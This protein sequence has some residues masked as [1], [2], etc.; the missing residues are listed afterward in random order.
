MVSDTE[1]RRRQHDVRG[2]RHRRGATSGT[3]WAAFPK[4]PCEEITGRAAAIA[5]IARMTPSTIPSTPARRITPNDTVNGVKPPQ[6]LPATE[7]GELASIL[8]K[9]SRRMNT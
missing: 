7:D 9:T 1:S 4:S 8:A 6:W 2:A 5:Y 3:R